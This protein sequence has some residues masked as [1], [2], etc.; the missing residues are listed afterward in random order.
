M[1]K[2]A[3]KAP[4][5]KLSDLATTRINRAIRDANALMADHD[6]YA[7]DLVE[8]VPA[9]DNPETRDAVLVLKEILD[10]LERLDRQFDLRNLR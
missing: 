10:G 1:D 3:K 5:S 2:L 7:D 8:F 6:R 9:G 4:S